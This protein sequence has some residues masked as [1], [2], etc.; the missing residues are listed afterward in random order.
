MILEASMLIDRLLD[1][2][3]E[4]QAP[5]VVGLDP[6]LDRL[7]PEILSAAYQAHGEN[8]TG[9]AAAMLAFNHMIIDQIYDLVPAVKPQM[10]YYEQLGW[11]GMEVFED[12]CQ[13]AASKGLFVIAD[14]K[15]GDIG[16]T[17]AAYASAYLGGTMSIDWL[18]VNPYLGDDCLKTFIHEIDVHDKG[19][20]A[21]V[22]TS[23][24][25]SAQLQDVRI[26]TGERVYEVVARMIEKWSSERVGK[27][28]YSAVGAVVGATYP[29]EL[30]S[31]RTIMPTSLFLVPGY[32]AQGGTAKDIVSALD[33]KGLGALVNSSRG[34]IYASPLEGETSAEAIR[35]ATVT[36]KEDLLQARRAC[37]KK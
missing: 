11:H 9:A 28:G 1:K 15:R 16:S 4:Q 23:N 14:G 12:T 36:M 22:K 10:A 7:P 27:E 30:A 8:R 17:S 32:G 37:Q 21:L 25:S 6:S 34:I 31:L 20:F 24:P 18:T 35:R 3:K 19:M 29:E 33:S 5:I 2:I 26:E 13:Y